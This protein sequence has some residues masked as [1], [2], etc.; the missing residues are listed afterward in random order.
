MKLQVRDIPGAYIGRHCEVVN[1]NG[2]RVFPPD[3]VRPD[4]WREG[5]T[6]NL[7]TDRQSCEGF[8]AGYAFAQDTRKRSK[9]R[10]RTPAGVSTPAS[11]SDPVSP[12]G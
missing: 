9:P 6:I 12:A 2:W 1:S 3:N 4:S 10:R 5:Q 8:I 7:G 11:R